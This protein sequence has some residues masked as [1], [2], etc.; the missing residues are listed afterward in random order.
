M[1]WLHIH[2]KTAFLHLSVWLIG[3]GGWKLRCRPG[4]D[5]LQFTGQAEKCHWA[6]IANL[7]IFL[8]QCSFGKSHVV[9]SHTVSAI[10]DLIICKA[11]ISQHWSSSMVSLPNKPKNAT[12]SKLS[13]GLNF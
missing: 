11:I 8:K 12:G 10:F 4:L 6:E 2:L 7:W 13:L 3:Q 1:E 9:K 5:S